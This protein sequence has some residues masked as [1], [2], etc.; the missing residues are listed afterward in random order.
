MCGFVRKSNAF[1][2]NTAYVVVAA[3]AFVAL[4][5]LAAA[6]ASAL[7]P[8]VDGPRINPGVDDDDDNDDDSGDIGFVTNVRR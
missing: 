5:A 7:N 1:L 6:A 4:M 2:F 8:D 3:L